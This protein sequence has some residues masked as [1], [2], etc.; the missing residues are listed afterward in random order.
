MA[1]RVRFGLPMLLLI[2]TLA[3][4]LVGS[5]AERARIQARAVTQLR[6]QGAW[7]IYD[8]KDLDAE[9]ARPVVFSPTWIQRSLGADFVF[10]VEEV[11]F[12]PVYPS[13]PV[14]QFHPMTTHVDDLSALSRLPHVKR[15]SLSH[16]DVSSLEHLASLHTL[17]KLNISNTLVQDLSPLQSLTRLRDV[18]LQCTAVTSLHG[19]E[20]AIELRTLDCGY[21]QVRDL[22]ALRPC[23]GLTRID[24]NGTKVVDLTPLHG[25]P[26][27]IVNLIGVYSVS[28]EEV[29]ALRAASP[30]N[31]VI[32]WDGGP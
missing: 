9:G 14:S 27:R 29:E 30:A 6:D 13:L 7:V 28:A 21:S 5:W 3:C 11:D 8:Q 25:K 17:E 32:A 18:D 31:C 12:G 2:V 22:S 26:L 24:L 4:V 16:T 19:L 15:L 1:S 23:T 10:R 20:Q